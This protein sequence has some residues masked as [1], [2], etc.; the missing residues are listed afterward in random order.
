MLLGHSMESCIPFLT[1][2]DSCQR[3]IVVF[4]FHNKDYFLCCFNL[5]CLS[6]LILALD[7]VWFGIRA[8]FSPP[9]ICPVIVDRTAARP[10]SLRSFVFVPRSCHRHWS[11]FRECFHFAAV[12]DRVSQPVTHPAVLALI[13]SHNSL[14]VTALPHSTVRIPTLFASL[15]RMIQKPHPTVPAWR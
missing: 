4:Y 2:V 1:R 14:H 8:I 5:L 11:F 12:P 3:G 9:G 6:Q 13:I 7:P 15:I 10:T